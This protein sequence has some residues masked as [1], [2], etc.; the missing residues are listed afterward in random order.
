MRISISTFLAIV[1]VLLIGLPTGSVAGTK[2]PQQQLVK[3][4][5]NQSAKVNAAR[6]Q[7]R[8]L[9][10]SSPAYRPL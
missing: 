10:T 5:D 8:K 2:S 3:Q 4:V 1:V 9:L 6:Q 7:V